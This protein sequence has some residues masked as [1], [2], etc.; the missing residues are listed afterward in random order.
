MAEAVFS[1]RRAVEAYLVGPVL[2]IWLDVRAVQRTG[3]FATF[4]VQET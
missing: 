2:A 4:C 1:I 3:V